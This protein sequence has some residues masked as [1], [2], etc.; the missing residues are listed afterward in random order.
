MTLSTEEIAAERR[1]LRAE[2]GS[3]FDS[4][5]EILFRHDPSGI[6]FEDNTDEYETEARTILPRLKD[7]HSPEDVTTVVH[8]EFQRWFDPDFAG[9]RG[10]YEEIAKEVWRLWQNHGASRVN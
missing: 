3:L 2:Y 9:P 1:R 10:K 5:A 6:N 4:I 8:E 7:C